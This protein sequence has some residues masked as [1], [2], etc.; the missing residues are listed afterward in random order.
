MIFSLIEVLNYTTVIRRCQAVSA[1]RFCEDDFLGNMG[2]SRLVCTFYQ[3]ARTYGNL[4]AN[5]SGSGISYQSSSLL[6]C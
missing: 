3:I 2:M 6:S 5:L 1:F 4:S